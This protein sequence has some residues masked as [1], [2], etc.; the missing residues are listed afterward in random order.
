MKAHIARNQNAGVPLALGWNLLAADRGIL[1]GM[2]PAFGMKLLLVSPADAGRTVAQ[3]LGHG[4]ACIGR[5]DQLQLHPESGGH[6][7][8]DAPVGGRKIP[9]QR[10]RDAGILVAC[11][12]SF[13]RNTSFQ[14]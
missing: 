8:Q 2:A 4:P 1:E 11:N 13:H 10:Q 5:G 9:A 3:Q 6:P 14:G 12:M 7:F